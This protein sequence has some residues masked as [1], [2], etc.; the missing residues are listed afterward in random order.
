MSKNQNLTSTLAHE[1]WVV[2]RCTRRFKRGSQ[3]FESWTTLTLPL[4]LDQASARAARLSDHKNDH[5]L[6]SGVAECLPLF[7]K[8]VEVA[9]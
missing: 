2:Q 8:V 4:K 9:A 3:I 6:L 5:R 1:K 7:S